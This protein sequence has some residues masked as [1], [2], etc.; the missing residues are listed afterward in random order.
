MADD[1]EISANFP[2]EVPDL[3]GRLTSHQFGHRIETYCRIIAGA[4]GTQV[5]IQHFLVAVST[6][7]LLSGV[8]LCW[9]VFHARSSRHQSKKPLCQLSYVAGAD[10]A[11]AEGARLL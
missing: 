6:G 4:Y 2:C 8:A 5:I 7:I 9:T 11:S 3:L 10:E 1:D